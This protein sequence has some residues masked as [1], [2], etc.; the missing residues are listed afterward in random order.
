MSS[1]NDIKT[2]RELGKRYAE[3]AA[4]P[5]NA[6]RVQR[7]RNVNSLRPDRPI[8]W[9]E[10][11][12]WHEMDMDGELTL[13]CQ[14]E[15]LRSAELQLRRALYRWRHMQAD[16][17]LENCF[18]VEK[19]Y[20]ST[21]IGLETK[22]TTVAIDKRNHII[23]HHYEDQL[24]TEEKVDRLPLPVITARPELDAARLERVGEALNG[25]LPVKL[26]GHG[27]Y[28]AP[29]DIISRLRGVEA[30]LTDL[31][32]RPELMHKTIARFTDILTSQFEQMEE[33]GL[34]D[35]NI[36]SL[37]CTP[38]YVDG[39]PAA[40]YDGGRVRFKDIWFR[41]MA[42]IFGSVS[43]AMHEE[44]EL[45]YARKLMDRCALSYY[46]C[47]EPLDN[48][49]FLLKKIPNMRKIGVSPWANVRASAEAMEGGY[50]FARKPNPAMV[51]GT[52][53]AEAIKTEIRETVEACL[54]YKCPY[55]F[56]LK[57]ISTVSYR[58]QNLFE[59]ADI[60]E[61]TIDGYYK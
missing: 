18:Y 38:P 44:F 16:M 9:I 22:E 49:I 59:W 61:Q 3:A 23:S 28:Y 25:V 27:I 26:R 37:H 39:S 50:V 14:D 24:D 7:A 29:W 6:Q 2:V 55:E 54:A 45:Q 30:I 48:K 51:A 33:Q 15:T 12:P 58:P 35:Y 31:T 42:Q 13:L 19:A 60:V 5:V 47:C 8:V 36:A 43:P 11:I 57:D 40:D 10:E 53:D 56:V 32:E 46:G 34:L 52:L 20:D 17:V 41:G 4:D 1:D 21:E